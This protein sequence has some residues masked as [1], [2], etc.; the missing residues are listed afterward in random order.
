MLTNPSTILAIDPG[1]KELG[2]AVFAHGKLEYYGVKTFKQRQPPHVLL[3]EV[4]HCLSS[5]IEDHCPQVLVIEQTFLIQHHAELLKVLTAEIKQTALQQGLQV[6]EYAP[7]DVRQTICQSR[8]ATKQKAA[9]TLAER[10]PELSPL[11]K[12][13]TKWER[14]YWS[15]VFDAVAVGIVCLERLK[16]QQDTE[17]TETD[18]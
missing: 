13:T 15:H 2:V 4:A 16:A 18:Q 12:R 14:L 8:K 10:F 6:F 17:T 11:L 3:G 7:I 1:T 9:Q 5:L